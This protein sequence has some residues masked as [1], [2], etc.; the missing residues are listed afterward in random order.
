MNN[1]QKRTG[2]AGIIMLLAT[3]ALVVLHQDFWDWARVDPR[4]FGFLPIG[5]GYHAGFAIAASVLMFAFV[6]LLWPKHL[7]NV[8]PEDPGRPRDDVGH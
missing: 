6:Q 8:Q 1:G 3:V 7:E 4:L 5:L 2:A